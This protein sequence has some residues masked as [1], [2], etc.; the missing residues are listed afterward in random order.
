MTG[1]DGR[2]DTGPKNH[3]LAWD[4]SEDVDRLTGIPCQIAGRTRIETA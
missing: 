4:L 3:L 2:L 1:M